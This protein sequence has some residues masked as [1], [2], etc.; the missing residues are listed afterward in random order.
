MIFAIIFL[1]S[2]FG[3]Q[4]TRRLIDTSGQG[5]IRVSALSTLTFTLLLNILGLSYSGLPSAIFLGSSFL[6]MSEDHILSSRDLVWAS[7]IFSLIFY[8]VLP[9]NQG[10]GGALGTSAFISCFIIYQIKKNYIPKP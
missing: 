2:Q 8:Y 10:L 1:C 5:A 4:V 7:G 9:Y 3:S 6:G